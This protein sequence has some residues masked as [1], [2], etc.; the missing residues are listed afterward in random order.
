MEPS[1]LLPWTYFFC[2]IP[3][4]LQVGW[5][6]RALDHPEDAGV[7]MLFSLFIILAQ[8]FLGHHSDL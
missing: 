2:I 1:Y 5:L 6:Q 4:Q 8:S 3:G 7:L